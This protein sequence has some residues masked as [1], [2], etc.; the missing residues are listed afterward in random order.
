MGSEPIF[1]QPPCRQG[2]STRKLSR[3][4]KQRR[5]SEGRAKDEKRKVPD[6]GLRE[7]VGGFLQ[8]RVM[9]DRLRLNVGSSLS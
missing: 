5:E 1:C 3:K 8:S 6:G 7:T 9:A 2:G 4:K